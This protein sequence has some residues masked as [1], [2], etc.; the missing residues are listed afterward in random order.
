MNVFK[1]PLA[2]SMQSKKY[3]ENIL[4]KR[5]NSSNDNHAISTPNRLVPPDFV[6]ENSTKKDDYTRTEV[7]SNSKLS[8]EAVEEN[9]AL[10]LNNFTTKNMYALK[11]CM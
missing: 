8:S 4:L 2:Y 7:E 9:T 10:N 5:I 11:V 6:K 3:T 1:L